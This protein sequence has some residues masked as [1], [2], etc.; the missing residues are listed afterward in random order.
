MTRCDTL[1]GE[2]KRDTYSNPALNHHSTID[3]ML[4]TLATDVINFDVLD[5][6]I[7]FSDHLPLMCT[8]E[9]STDVHARKSSPTSN[10]DK[11]KP[12]E[13]VQ[14]RWDHAD[15]SSYYHFT[16]EHLKPI[17]RFLN[18]LPP[19]YDKS[20]NQIDFKHVLDHVY[21]DLVNTLAL[22]ANQ[23]VPQCRKKI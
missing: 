18:E 22:G 3:F 5:P 19:S 15:L 13:H 4:T 9:I 12:H 20:D 23:F 17:L 14:L 10:S 1:F 16:G 2:C 21:G 8:V 7:N 11:H 6:D